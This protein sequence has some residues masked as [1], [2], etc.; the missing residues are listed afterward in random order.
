MKMQILQTPGSATT[1]L[2]PASVTLTFGATQQGSLLLAFVMA[3]GTVSST[4]GTPANWGTV[5]NNATT[6]FRVQVFKYLNNPGGVTTA[7]F[8]L[9][10]AA[11]AAVMGLEIKGGLATLDYLV[12]AGCSDSGTT[13]SS[14][15]QN[16]AAPVY[17]NELWAMAIGYNSGATLNGTANPLYAQAGATQT[18]TTGSVNLKETLW[19]GKCPPMAPSGQSSTLALA[20]ANSQGAVFLRILTDEAVT[21]GGYSLISSNMGVQTENAYCGAIGS[22]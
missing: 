16:P 7:V 4:I 2:T 11:A 5:V 8:N 19:T 22:W 18:S 17:L 15:V 14:S 1:V 10:N 3:I 21:N 13:F 20:A 6:T 9:T 12:M